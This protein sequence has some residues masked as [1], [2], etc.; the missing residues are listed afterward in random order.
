MSAR[1]VA[2]PMLLGG[3]IVLVLMLAAAYG[4]LH[5]TTGVPGRSHSGPLSPLADEERALADRLKRHIETIAAR[6]HN[7][8]RYDE[9]E[10]SA[11]YIET[12]LAAF[13]YSVG[14]QEFVA[15]HSPVRNLDVVIEPRAEITD[16]EVIV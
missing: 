7:I 13:G 1:G 8:R 14:R 2:L 16:P 4:A 6:E 10:K 15:D 11:R 5:Y 9:L 12:T 3:A